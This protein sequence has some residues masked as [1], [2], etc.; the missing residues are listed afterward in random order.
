MVFHDLTKPDFEKIAA[1]RINELR[2]PLSE[3]GISLSYDSAAL[4]AIAEKSFGKKGGARDL[5]RVIRKDIEDRVCEL[6]VE[7]A[8][9]KLEAVTVTAENGEIVVKPAFKTPELPEGNTEKND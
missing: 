7:N 9:K 5:V 8:D 3:K 4:G 6:M 2:E 1:L